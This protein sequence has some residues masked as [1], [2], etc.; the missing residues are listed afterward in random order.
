MLGDGT[1]RGK[2]KVKEG[3]EKGKSGKGRE[4]RVV[5]SAVG[6]VLDV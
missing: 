1:R 3:E 4:Y 6:A 2:G 5:E